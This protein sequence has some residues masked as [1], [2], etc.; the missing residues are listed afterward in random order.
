MKRFISFLLVIMM[1]LSVIPMIPTM[2]ITEE[3]LTNPGFEEGDET[4][5]VNYGSCEMEVGEEYAHKGEYGMLLSK[6]ANGYA[7]WAQDISNILI[8]NGPG[9]YTASMWIRLAD[10]QEPCTVHLTMIVQPNGAEKPSYYTSGRKTLTTEWQQFTFKGKIDFDPVNGFKTALLY[11]Q[12]EGGKG[13]PDIMLDDFSLK[14]NG[15]VNGIPLDQVVVPEGGKLPSSTNTGTSGKELLINPGFEEGDET[16][17]EQYGAGSNMEVSEDYARTGEYGMLLSDRMG[18]YAT[19]AQDIKEQLIL[20]GPG[21]YFGSVWMKLSEDSKTSG[22]GQLVINVKPNGGAQRYYGSAQKQL[23][24]E[25]QEFAFKGTIDFDPKKGFEVALIYQQ[26]EAMPD[27]L[28]DDFTFKKLSAVN[29]ISLDEVEKDEYPDVEMK[30]IN[31]FKEK[32]EEKTTIGAIRWDAWYSHDGRAESIVSQVEKTLSPAEYHWRA[33]FFAKITEEGNIEMPEYTQ[34]I[35][36]KEM[37]YAIE[38]GIG[39]FAYLY[40]D[41]PMGTARKLHSTSK[42]KN[43]VKIVMCLDGNSIGK[44]GARAEIKELLKQEHYMT[45]LNGRPLMYYYVN[46]GKRKENMALVESE[47]KYYRGYCKSVGLPEPFVVC[48]NITGQETQSIYGDAVSRYSISGTS[49][50]TFKD[51]ITE[52]QSQWEGYQK[53]G[54]QY[55]PMMTFGWHAEPR[56]KNPVTWMTTTED[57]WVPYPTDQEIYD[58]T[59]YALSYMDHSMTTEFTKLNTLI[60]YAWNE[61]DEGSWLCPTLKVD[62][63][64]NQLYNEDGTPMVDDSRVQM[65]KK[66]FEDFNNGTRT[67][68]VINGIS[69]MKDKTDVPQAT[70]PIISDE[71]ENNNSSFDIMDYW[72]ILPIAVVVIAGVFVG[73]IILNKKKKEENTDGENK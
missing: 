9:E 36:D 60:L 30:H 47:I 15:E 58:H 1:V 25:W 33:P 73:I 6:R 59:M 53:S 57:S 26:S 54:M 11:Q 28:I 71:T 31:A 23:T 68:I 56:Y 42:Y 2:A 72:W 18:K 37:E 38:A 13:S 10:G 63:N 34:E 41:G 12:S 64:G 48:M 29:G 52:A 16:G 45:V 51:F 3:L 55:V 50:K 17:F 39:Y 5:F 46:T 27:I 19:W 14:K 61:H 7:T 4:G 21:E 67:E 44:S 62:E 32:R 8:L 22:K 24:T 20:N 66:A 65:V 40:Y 70:D 49:D 43:D 69:N 35:F